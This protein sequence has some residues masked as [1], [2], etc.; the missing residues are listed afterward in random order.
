[1][2]FNIG[3]KV[4]CRDDRGCSD[5]TSLLVFNQVYEVLDTQ[6]TPCGCKFEVIDVGLRMTKPEEH[7]MCN[8]TKEKC[9]SR[10]MPGRGIRWVNA[11]R[12]VKVEDSPTTIMKNEIKN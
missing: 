5:A 7:T 6:T 2:I 10:E 12:F 11:R 3:D 8:G 1:M 4:R 9:G